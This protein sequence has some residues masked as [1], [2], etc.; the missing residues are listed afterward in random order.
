M[1]FLTFSLSIFDVLG[2]KLIF[3]LFFFSMEFSHSHLIFFLR[4]Q[5]RSWR[6]FNKLGGYF[7]IILVR[8]YLDLIIVHFFCLVRFIYCNYLF[9]NHIIKLTKLI[10]PNRVNYSILGLFYL[11]M[12]V[13]PKNL[14]YVGEIQLSPW[15]STSHQFSKQLAVITFMNNTHMLLLAI[16]LGYL[17]N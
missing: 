7:F 16:S 10:E 1:F 12:L 2:I 5:I 14:F 17:Y 6:P 15:C 8:V 3:F 11:K 9:F 4:Y 13:F